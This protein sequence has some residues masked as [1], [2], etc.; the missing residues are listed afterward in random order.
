MRRTDVDDVARTNDHLDFKIK[1]RGEKINNT[2]N[3]C[4]G[5]RARAPAYTL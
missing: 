3:D 1:I 5:A 2:L 4:D